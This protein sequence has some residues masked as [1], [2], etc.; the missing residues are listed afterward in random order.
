[1]AGKW[2]IGLLVIKINSENKIEWLRLE[3][4]KLLKENDIMKLKKIYVL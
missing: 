3:I 2:L 4:L 1:M